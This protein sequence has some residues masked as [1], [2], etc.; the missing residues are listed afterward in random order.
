MSKY[1][2]IKLMENFFQTDEVKIIMKEDNGANY[3]IFWLKL[4]LKA[5]INEET[6][7][8]RYKENI[9][10][11]PKTL[12]TITDTPIDTV[13]SALQIFMNLNMVEL[14]ENGELWIEEA[15]KLVGSEGKSAERMR[16]LRAKEK[17][18]RIEAS[19]SDIDIDKD[20]DIDIDIEKEYAPSAQKPSVSLNTFL[21]SL[22]QTK[23]E[24]FVNLPKEKQE[25]EYNNFL[26]GEKCF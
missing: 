1:Y 20:I 18:K 22:P 17:Q 14:R 10:F 2:W 8:I 23:R 11:T 6:G 25:E 4:L 19:H 15:M 26:D 5:A 12:A 21:K 13:R 9:P 24:D 7:V 16:R 3:V